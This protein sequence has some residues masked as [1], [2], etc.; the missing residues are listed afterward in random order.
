MKRLLLPSLILSLLAA[1]AA[2]EDLVCRVK[3]NGAAASERKV[4]VSPNE[5]VPYAELEGYRFKI[6][7]LGPS[8]FEIE[9]Y[10]SAAPSRGYAAGF[11][12]AAGDAVSWTLW[13]RDILL[14]TTCALS[15]AG[16][17]RSFVSGAVSRPPASAPRWD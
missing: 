14:E 7:N 6:K 17:G 8:R 10:D 4:R 3:V 12:R 2:A 11:L 15:A 5:S 13:T 1:N 9:A 16:A